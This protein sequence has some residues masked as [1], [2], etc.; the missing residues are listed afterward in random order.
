MERCRARAPDS[1]KLRLLHPDK[2]GIRNDVLLH[3]LP[4]SSF[5]GKLKAPD[6][7]V[8]RDFDTQP[9]SIIFAFLQNAAK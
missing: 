8:H 5:A 3:A 1:R 7:T 6:S 4:E 9:N 2:I